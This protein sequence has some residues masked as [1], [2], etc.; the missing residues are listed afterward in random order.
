MKTMVV[1][2]ILL[3]VCLPAL[4]ADGEIAVTVYNSN[5]GV[6]SEIRSLEFKKGVGQLAYTDVPSQIDAASVRFDLV[7]SKDG[8]S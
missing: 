4:A 5:L 1:S 7:G 3:A 2:L 8:V 6:V